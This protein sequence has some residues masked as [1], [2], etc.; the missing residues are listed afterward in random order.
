L[1]IQGINA[2][3]FISFKPNKNKKRKRMSATI[4][5]EVKVEQ[6]PSSPLVEHLRE[7]AKRYREEK[8]VT[9]E[10]Y[11]VAGEIPNPSELDE[12]HDWTELELVFPTGDPDA[13]TV[14][15]KFIYSGSEQLLGSDV[16]PTPETEARV[17]ESAAI[18]LPMVRL[19]LDHYRGVMG[20][21]DTQ[22]IACSVLYSRQTVPDLE[23]ALA[24]ENETPHIDGDYENPEGTVHYLAAVGGFPTKIWEGDFKYDPTSYKERDRDGNYID[25][26]QQANAD[27]EKQIK[28]T[29]TGVKAKRVET[30]EG[31]LI[32]IDTQHV[33]ASP[34]TDMAQNPEL[35]GTE[36]GFI[37][38]SFKLI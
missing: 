8:I 7:K 16:V 27:L 17:I 9:S 24:N 38:I 10:V 22:P 3:L 28:R 6:E 19:A 30:Q 25:L 2:I 21:A 23:G 13:Y 15:P 4:E 35:V 34:Y 37:V 32:C 36:R 18:M 5:D 33:H 1:T 11:G 20:I 12:L 14:D 26:I 31:Q 29:R